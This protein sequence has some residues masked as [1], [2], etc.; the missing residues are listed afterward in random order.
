MTPRTA[1]FDGLRGW[2]A[3][4]VVLY[5]F[6]AGLRPPF[7]HPPDTDG[8]GSGGASA[9]ALLRLVFGFVADGE[10]AVA[11]F[12]ILS[13]IVLS[14]A[15]ASQLKRSVDAS[16]VRPT[17]LGLALKRYVRLGLPMVGSAVL[18]YGAFL[19]FT[20]ADFRRL[21]ELAELEPLNWPARMADC[22]PCISPTLGGALAE[23]IWG[24]YLRRPDYNHV[25]WTIPIEF[26]GSLLIF[27]FMLYF[28]SPGARRFAA[29]FAF[30]AGAGSYFS[31]FFLGMLL[32][33][34]SPALHRYIRSG[35]RKRWLADASGL[36]LIAL[37]LTGLAWPAVFPA[38]EG[39]IADGLRS[40][41]F[42]P[43]AGSP[44]FVRAALVTT[45]CFL[46]PSAQCL[47][48]GSLS[49]FLGRVSFSLYLIHAAIL[50]I[51][52]FPLFIRFVGAGADPNLVTLAL[53]LL[54]T[55]IMLG[56]AAFYFG[57]VERPSIALAGNLGRTVDR[58]LNRVLKMS[59]SWYR[60]L[61][62]N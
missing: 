56:L 39:A 42:I 40:L 10:L 35:E 46:S 8:I 62:R 44:A 18:G 3:L 60:T 41:S 45:G 11:I 37:G 4:A 54:T 13:G 31:E 26:V 24:T 33:E 27:S 49:V 6:D 59:L 5:H 57:C 50:R 30:L 7:L 17:F 25:L 48:S 12:F 58:N 16:H 19:F 22:G 9:W 51:V 14:S 23:G 55:P 61:A 38:L 32:F 20:G 36:F 28:R 29:S 53:V 1:Y 47:L 34:L 2:A 15:V 21:A 52:V 43:W